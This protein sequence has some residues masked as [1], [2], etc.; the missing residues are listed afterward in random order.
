MVTFIGYFLPF[1]TIIVFVVGMVYRIRVWNKLPTPKMTL[2][3]AP[4]PGGSRFQEVLKETFFFKRLFKGDKNLWVMGWFFHVMLAFIF[5]GHLRVFAWI[6]DKMLGSLGMSAENIDTMSLVTGGAAGIIILL[7]LLFILGRRFVV[8]RVREISQSGDYFALI[9]ILL[10]VI[11]GDAMRFLSHFDLAQT[12][13]YF[14]GL[15]VFSFAPIPA[16]SW[17]IVHFLLA[18][19]LIMYIPFSK[20]LHF[21]GIFFSEALLHKQ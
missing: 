12:R 9:L 15:V 20:I 21:G 11:T 6:P 13:E 16:N 8:K 1:I 10:I 14:Y 18:Q 3:P 7:S 2:F 19:V 4:N 5:L 17:F